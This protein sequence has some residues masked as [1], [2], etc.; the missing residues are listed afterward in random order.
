MNAD[1]PDSPDTPDHAFARQRLPDREEIASLDLREEAPHAAGH[2]LFMAKRPYPV[3]AFNGYRK[4]GVG[5]K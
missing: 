1:S 5:D 3:V 2:P 4:I